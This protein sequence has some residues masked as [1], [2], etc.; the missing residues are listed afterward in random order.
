M[1]K[2]LHDYRF[3]NVFT[4]FQ[5]LNWKN[6]PEQMSI[7]NS[8]KKTDTSVLYPRLSKLNL[9]KIATFRHVFQNED[10]GNYVILRVPYIGNEKW[11]PTAKWDTVYFIVKAEA[12]E[13]TK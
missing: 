9:Y 6:I 10:W 13:E 2:A 1:L 4:T 7:W 3:N 12:V 8:N 5:T 11:D